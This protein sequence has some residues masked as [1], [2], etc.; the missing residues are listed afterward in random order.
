E[1]AAAAAESPEDAEAAEA[2]GPTLL[3]VTESGMGK[4]SRIGDY[5]LQGR[6][7]KGVINIRI[8]DKTGEVVAIKGVT[9]EDELVMITR[10]G[11]VNRQPVREIRVIGRNTQGVRLIALDEGDEVM[12]VA[13]LVPEDESKEEDIATLDAELTP[14]ERPAGVEAAEDGDPDGDG[15]AGPE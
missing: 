10:N 2:A 1:A 7:G 15:L 14:G 8:T 6:G 9:P 11:V 4:R 13:R 12:D 5:R 3:V